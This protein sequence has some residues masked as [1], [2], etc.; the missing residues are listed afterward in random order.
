MRDV[1]P[2]DVR[3]MLASPE[4]REYHQNWHVIRLLDALA[5]LTPEERAALAAQGWTAPRPRGC[6]DRFGVGKP[7]RPHDS[8][9][10]YFRHFPARA[11]TARAVLR[12]LQA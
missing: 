2:D 5:D 8:A 10:D 3:S 1:L 9:R 12:A 7:R 4:M 11:R 6:F